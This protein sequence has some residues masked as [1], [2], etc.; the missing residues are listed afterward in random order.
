MLNGWRKLDP[1][2]KAVIVGIAGIGLAVLLS[3]LLGQIGTG[4]GLEILFLGVLVL[5]TMW[6]GAHAKRM[7]KEAKKQA[8]IMLNAQFNAVAPVI[9]LDAGGTKTI[10]I[11]WQNVGVAS[12][13]NFRCWIEDEEYPELRNVRKAVHR[14]VVA[15]SGEGREQ[16]IDTEIEGYTL[17]IG[18]VRAQYESILGKTY[19]SC[20]LFPANAA[21]ELKY[22]E[23]KEIIIL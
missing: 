18:Y 13:L 17:G 15:L 22:G 14:T 19:E 3:I 23:A 16:D 11:G 5:V 1:D 4:Y 8:E 21:P 6:Y 2:I 7:A 12:A 9:E 10:R 20:L